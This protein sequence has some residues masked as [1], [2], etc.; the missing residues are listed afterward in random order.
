[1]DKTLNIDLKK[2]LIKNINFIVSPNCDDR[3]DE[4]D[5]S[6][7]VIHGISLPPNKFGGKGVEQ[8]FCN[9][10]DPTEDIFYKKIYRLRLSSHLYIKRTGQIIQFVPFNKRAWHAGESSFKNRKSCNDFSIGIELEGADYIVYTDEQYQQLNSLLTILQKAYPQTLNNI[11][12]HN[13][14]SPNRKTDPGKSFD[15]QKLL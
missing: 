5:I 10:L 8:L 6:L 12:G 1:M 11:V 13:H 3:P 15:W 4:K 14:I 2:H 7:I 9:K